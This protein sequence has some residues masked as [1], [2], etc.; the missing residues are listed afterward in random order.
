MHCAEGR[1]TL[2]EFE[3]RLEGVL[4][5][6][7]VRELGECLSDLPASA[8]VARPAEP[9][10]RVRIGPPGLLP[11]THHLVVPTAPERIRALALE[12][13]APDLNAYGYEL[14]S[15]SPTDLIFERSDRPGWTVAAAVFLFPIGP[16]ALTQ[17]KT[18][19]IVISLERHA[20]GG[21]AM[22]VY[23]A[24]PRRIRKA[25]AELID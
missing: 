21:T 16:L 5:A 17:R 20:G 13:I 7:T 19:R 3:G 18:L 11:F 24:A 23:G 22:T 8:S 2:E 1:I 14:V 4:A 25:F 6:G 15:R 10:P 12:K 9:T